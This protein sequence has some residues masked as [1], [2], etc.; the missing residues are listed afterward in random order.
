M[1]G[2]LIVGP[3][4]RGMGV[5]PEAQAPPGTSRNF[6]VFDPLEFLA[7]ITQHIP[8]AGMQ[9]IRYDGWYSNKARGQRAKAVNTAA[10]SE[11]IDID[12]EDTPYRKLCRMRWA[13]LVKRVFEVDPSAVR[14]AA[15]R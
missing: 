5:Y 13:A 8:D 3:R 12:E 10:A 1:A 14:N 7:G 15:A 4:S 11:E 9:M 6:E 2:P